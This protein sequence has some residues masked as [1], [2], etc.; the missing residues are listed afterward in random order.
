M[1]SLTETAT[2]SAL[3][4]AERPRERLLEHGSSV[5]ADVE[6]VAVLLRTGGRGRSALDVART[7]L[8]DCGGLVG[9]LSAAP[10]SLLGRNLGPAKA[11]SV[12]A[13]VE[14]G[15]RF[16]R[17]RLPY[18]QPLERPEAVAD[19]LGLRYSCRDQ[20]VMGVLYLD[21]RQRLMGES[22]VFRG[23]LNRAAAEPRS[24]LK[25]G[26]LRDAAGFI[27]F[28]THPSG[29]PTPSSEDLAFTRRVADAGD[30]V[31]V[32]LVDHLIIGGSGRW[33]SLRRQNAW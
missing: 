17:A 15:R 7:L 32:R 22:E 19:Y 30:I 20:E 11:S 18:R 3:D 12:L 2:L 33:V 5:L 1:G 31:G 29:D 27:L 10:Q 23:T 25:H 13:A 9:L 24:I 6:L 16:A 28:H 14:L 8:A 21:T 26:L 4:P